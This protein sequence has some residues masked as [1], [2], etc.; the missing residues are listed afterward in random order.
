MVHSRKLFGNG[1]NETTIFSRH[2]LRPKLKHWTAPA[3][4]LR[5][6]LTILQSKLNHCAVA[7][8]GIDVS[9]QCTVPWNKRSVNEVERSF[10]K[11]KLDN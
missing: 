3:Q 5:F 6:R 8:I 1:I 2:Q 10:E 4:D 7:K 9:Q 11:H